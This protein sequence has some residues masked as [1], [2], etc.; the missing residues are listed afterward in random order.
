MGSAAP[1]ARPRVLNQTLTSLPA[2]RCTRRW[3][4]LRGNIRRSGWPTDI[5]R[6]SIGAASTYP[7][8]KSPTGGA[9]QRSADGFAIRPVTPNDNRNPAGRPYLRSLALHRFSS[10]IAGWTRRESITGSEARTPTS[11]CRS[12]RNTSRH[13]P[14]RCGQMASALVYRC[15]CRDGFTDTA[16][17][18]TGRRPV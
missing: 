8:R 4:V 15:L 13:I 1:R 7:A 2:A 5:R 18:G 9:I 14:R 16:C 6:R 11:N 10:S 12:L 3:R 17:R